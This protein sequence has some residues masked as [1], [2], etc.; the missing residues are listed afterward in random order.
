VLPSVALPCPGI[1]LCETTPPDIRERAEGLGDGSREHEGSMM[2]L[3][4][5]EWIRVRTAMKL[6]T[7]PLEPIFARLRGGFSL[8]KNTY[9]PVPGGEFIN[10]QNLYPNTTSTP[11]VAVHFLRAVSS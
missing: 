9:R 7:W 4:P 1:F 11:P 10:T 2:E 3:K 8:Q 5:G 6:H